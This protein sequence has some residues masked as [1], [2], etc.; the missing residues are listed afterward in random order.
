MNPPKQIVQNALAHRARRNGQRVD[1]KLRK[2]GAQYCQPAW[3]HRHAIGL[4][5]FELRAFEAAC[6]DESSAQLLD[7]VG[8][9]R[10]FDEAVRVGDLRESPDRARRADRLLPLLFREACDQRLQL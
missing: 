10:T 4:Q 5:S 1:G 9:D 2:Y 6:F 3:E 7:A 8:S